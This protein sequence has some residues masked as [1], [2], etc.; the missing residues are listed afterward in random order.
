VVKTAQ[1]EF[2][3]EIMGNLRFTASG[4]SDFPAVG[5]WVA[6]SEYDENKLLIHAI[7]PRRNVLERKAVGKFAEKQIIAAN[8]DFALVVQAL[9]RDFNLNRIERYLAICYD[10]A[11]TPILLFNKS[12]L[13]TEEELKERMQ[14][15]NERF[16]ELKC[17]AISNNTRVGYDVLNE[18]IIEGYT[19][20]LLGSSGVGKST[21]VNHISGRSLMSTGAI[22]ESTSKGRH[23]TSH[24]ELFVLDQGGIIIDNPG[25][26]ELGI[27]DASEGFEEVFDDIARLSASCRY[28]DCEHVHEAACAVIEAVEDGRIERAH[29]EN[30]LK[31]LREKEHFESSQA[32]IKKKGKDLGKV[33]KEH[34]RFKKR[35]EPG[36]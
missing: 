12:D 4:R 21:L 24:R 31:I 1:G 36:Y 22:S 32:D 10:S 7:F 11:V 16:P 29:Y 3:A 34:K 6:V 28:M 5:D 2:D 30:Y 26:R 17:I 9:D 18:Q 19:Y 25:M 35:N 15:A 13:L 23:V 20:C 8:V 27:A 14:W 33:I